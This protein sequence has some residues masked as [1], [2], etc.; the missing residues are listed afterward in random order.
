M[1]TGEGF[2]LQK[3]V[4]IMAYDANEAMRQMMAGYIKQARPLHEM[5]FV[6][7]KTA[8]VTGGTSGLGF[9]IALRLLQG[10]ANVVVA[11]GSEKKGET[12]VSLFRMEGYGEDR[13]KYCKTDVSREEDVIRLVDFTDKAFRSVDILV[14]SVGIWNYAH[15]YHM[16]K[17]DFNHIMEV[18]VTGL[19][20]CI[21]HVSRYMIDHK[22]AGKITAVS[23]NCPW[24]P[25]PV[26][27][28]YPHY[29]ASKG[30]VNALIVE[31][32][33][34][35]KRYNIMVNAVAPGGMA[36]PGASSNLTAKNL[37]EEQSDE[38]Y[39][40]L[41]VWSI[42]STQTVDSVAIVAYMLSSAV[43]DGITGEVVVADAGAS[44]NIVHHQVA[45]EAYPPE[46]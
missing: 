36:T 25:Y 7:G 41:M 34:E 43:S 31:A 12:A 33:K 20:L 24:M 3:G 45:I 10:G 35:L 13:V 18:N 15:I 9:N 44:H 27:G 6:E 14:N 40:E 46:E 11:S 39:D 1:R 8:I 16:A 21:K 30:A 23:S 32:A 37:T 19:F 22:I 5:L 2:D 17:E 38:F 26:F 28:G 4:F 29:A 42:D